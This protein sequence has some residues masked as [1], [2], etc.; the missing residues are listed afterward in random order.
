MME[1]IQLLNCDDARFRYRAGKIEQLYK[2][3]NRRSKLENSPAGRN[4]GPLPM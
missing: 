2:E 1:V 3:I 4:N